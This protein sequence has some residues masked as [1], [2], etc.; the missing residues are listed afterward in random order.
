M[1]RAER[2]RVRVRISRRQPGQD[3]AAVVACP[4][5]NSVSA[6]VEVEPGYFRGVV[7][8]DDSCPWYAALKRD[9]A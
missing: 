8:H 6:V 9:L 3:M 2:R 1:N 4:D 5:C 7:R